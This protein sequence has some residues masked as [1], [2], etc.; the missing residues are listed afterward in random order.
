MTDGAPAPQ[1]T[2]VE[3]AAERVSSAGASRVAEFRAI[4]D[5]ELAWTWNALRRLGVPERHL[6]DVAH[7][8]F[9]VLYRKLDEYDRSR[10]LRPWIFG[11]AHRVAS[12]FRRKAS[13]AREVPDESPAPVETAPDPEAQLEGEHARALLA[14]ALDALDDDK[15]AV[16]VLHELEEEPM[17]R[18]AEAL[19]IPLN[20]AYSRLRL[21][22]RDFTAA[23]TRLRARGDA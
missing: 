12:D 23:V 7:D 11:I 20:T 10:P 21:A 9:V 17:P 22:R 5:A 3:P 15:R 4:Y 6:E 14:R 19:A 16:F 13:H 1:C 8:V 2:G 18:I